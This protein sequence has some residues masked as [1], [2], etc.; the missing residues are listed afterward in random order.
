MTSEKPLGETL[1]QM[2]ALLEGER[3]ALAALDLERILTC[4]DGKMQLC[5][6]IERK[7]QGH[8]DEDARG[9][10]DAV[11]RLNEINRKMRNLIAAN[12][13]ARLGSLTGRISLYGGDRPAVVREMPL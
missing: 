5:E 13:E 7:A 10:L 12:V 3:Q 2:L 6:Q 9:L 11:T 8:L 1:R 4:A